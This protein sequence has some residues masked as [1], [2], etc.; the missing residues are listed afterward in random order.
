[1][2]GLRAMGRMGEKKNRHGDGE[3]GRWGENKD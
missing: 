1:M 2:T 3:K